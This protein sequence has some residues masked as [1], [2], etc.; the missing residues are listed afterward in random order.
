MQKIENPCPLPWTSH[1]GLIFPLLTSLAIIVL[2]NSLFINN[3]FYSW[4]KFMYMLPNTVN[5]SMHPTITP[6]PLGL[7]HT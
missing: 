6:N 5:L 7:P 3:S 2:V 4:L 1:K